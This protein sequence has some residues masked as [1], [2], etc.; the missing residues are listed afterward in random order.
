MTTPHSSASLTVA[1]D[2]SSALAQLT[3]Q[4]KA[5]PAIKHALCLRSAW[6]LSN[7]HSFFQLYLVAPNMSGY[8]IDQFVQRE[9]VAALKA[10]VKAWVPFVVL[11]CLTVVVICGSPPADLFTSLPF[12]YN[13]CFS[14]PNSPQSSVFLD[15]QGAYVPIP[16]A[17]FIY[18]N[19]GL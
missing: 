4:H 18:C 14:V 17:P 11:I 3:K 16:V 15:D 19:D 2:L 13:L 6:A 1:A 5:D 10:M 9:R 7:Y 8:L 12:L